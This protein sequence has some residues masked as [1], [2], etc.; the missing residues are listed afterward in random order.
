[1]VKKCRR[2][3]DTGG[4][5][6]RLLA[7]GRKNAVTSAP[8]QFQAEDEQVRHERAKFGQ[9]LQAVARG[10]HLEAAGGRQPGM[11]IARRASS[12]GEEYGRHPWSPP[13]ARPRRLRLQWASLPEECF[14]ALE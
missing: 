4:R 11:N 13:W 3:H 5:E 6:L 7:Q 9:A 12:V 8:R 1:M 2:E 14:H 10:I